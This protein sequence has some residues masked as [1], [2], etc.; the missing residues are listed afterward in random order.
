MERKAKSWYRLID[1][2]YLVFVLVIFL[3]SGCE[4]TNDDLFSQLKPPNS[5]SV[6]TVNVL[7]VS[8]DEQA[9]ET[10]VF[11]GKLKPNRQARLGFGRAGKLKNIYKQIG[12]QVK[13]G[14]KLA[15]L[16]QDQLEIRKRDIEQALLDANQNF[17][18][19]ELSLRPEGQ[20]EI[21]QLQSQLQTVELELAKGSILAPYDC[22]VAETIVDP[23]NLVGQQLP[24][25]KVV[26]NSQAL[27]E[28][29]LPRRIA[30]RLS[31]G[32]SIWVGVGDQAVSAQT[33]AK[34]PVESPVGSKIIT[35]Q[36]TGE[37]EPGSWSFGQA[38]KIR[39]FMPTENSGFWLPFSALNR[40]SG[41]LWSTLVIAEDDS[42]DEANSES[43]NS[44]VARKIL[45]LVQLENDWALVQGALVDGE[46]VIVNGS[47][48][49][50]AGQRVN[51]NDVTSQFVKPG[52]GANE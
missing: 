14:E 33:K 23:G 25:L 15:E 9:M 32:Q 3:A 24:V 8:R 48:R 29:S 41:G 5:A 27:V 42:Q 20:Q 18:P 21:R 22:I 38:V 49:I 2:R 16:E 30:D 47:H 51:T 1:L 4:R 36:I 6:L 31:V 19:G 50:V 44:T 40:E 46:F 52:A 35:F 28:S 12:E 43:A 11:F 37:L 10:A 39:F 45:E 17:Q 13:E 26:E 34:S 7:R